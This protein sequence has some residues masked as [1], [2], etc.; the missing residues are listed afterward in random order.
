MEY[1]RHRGIYR[2]RHVR[3]CSQACTRQSAV[4]KASQI[5]NS[6]NQFRSNDHRG[7]VNVSDCTAGCGYSLR[8]S[9]FAP[10]EGIGRGWGG[11]SGVSGVGCVVLG[12]AGRDAV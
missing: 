4:T 8:A 3:A 12:A 1:E 9:M 5:G 2:A 7:N 6:F 11:V 10:R